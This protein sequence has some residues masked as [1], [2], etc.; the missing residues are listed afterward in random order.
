MKKI[1]IGAAITLGFLFSLGA[2]PYLYNH[3]IFSLARLKNS[4]EIGDDYS[5]IAKRFDEYDLAHKKNGD[6]Q[7]VIEESR[8]FIYH[9]STFDDCQLTVSFDTSGKVKNIDYVGD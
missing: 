6:L 8:L 5:L 4:V 2:W 3:H 9:V 7:V 1:F